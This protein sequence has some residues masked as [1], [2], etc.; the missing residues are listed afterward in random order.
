MCGRRRRWN[1][2]VQSPDQAFEVW[3]GSPKRGDA[4]AWIGLTYR[5]NG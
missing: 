5:C 4:Y 3:K 2:N 1:L